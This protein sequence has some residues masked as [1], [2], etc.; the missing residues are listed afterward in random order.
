MKIAAFATA[1]LALTCLTAPSSAAPAQQPKSIHAQGCV[2]AGVENRCLIVKDRKTGTLY[3][4]LIKDPRPNIGE[5][6][7][8]TGTPHDGPSTCMQG[9]AV[10]VTSWTRDDSFKCSHHQEPAK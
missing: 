3:N 4:V 2:D 5:G 10:D 6:I 7:E 1:A 9:V 8:F